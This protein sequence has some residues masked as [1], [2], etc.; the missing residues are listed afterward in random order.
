MNIMHAVI[1]GSALS[2]LILASSP[3][4]ADGRDEYMKHL[5]WQCEHGDH[6]ACHMLRLHR[7]CEEGDRHACE[8]LHEEERH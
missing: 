6:E 4:N 5:N 1:I 2:M 3:A 8:R 7:D